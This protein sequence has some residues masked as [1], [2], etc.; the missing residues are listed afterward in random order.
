MVAR[1]RERAK[2]NFEFFDLATSSM[3]VLFALG[4]FD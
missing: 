2:V 3:E 1:N 4:A